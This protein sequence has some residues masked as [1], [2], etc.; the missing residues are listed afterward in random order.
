MLFIPSPFHA[1]SSINNF[2]TRNC[3]ENLI[4]PKENK[5]QTHAHM[6]T[7]THTRTTVTNP[8]TNSYA[9]HNSFKNIIY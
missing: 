3:A 1:H 2:A 8:A 5:T 9:L 6:H 7:H 4:L